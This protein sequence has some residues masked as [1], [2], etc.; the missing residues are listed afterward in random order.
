MGQILT[1]ISG[2]GRNGTV[3]SGII[4]TKDGLLFSNPNS[5]GVAITT[6]ET[7]IG[8]ITISLRF[9]VNATTGVQ[10]IFTNG[11]FAMYAYL[12]AI[13][14][15]RNGA[16]PETNNNINFNTWYN[17][18]IASTSA[19]VTN[20]YLNG[21][22]LTTITLTVVAGSNFYIGYDPLYSNRGFIG[23]IAD[24]RIYNRVLTLQEIKDYNNSFIQ[25]TLLEDYSDAGAD[26]QVSV[27]REWT[28]TSGTF[29]VAEN[30]IRQGAAYQSNF[31]TTDSWT[32]ALGGSVVGGVTIG[33]LANCLEYT[34][35]GGS[36]FHVAQISPI[37]TIVLGGRYT[38]KGK[39]YFPASGNANGF[40]IASSDGI[41]VYGTFTPITKDAWYEFSLNYT[42]IGGNFN[43]FRVIPLVNGSAPFS[44]DGQKYYL[45]D[46]NITEIQPLQT[47]TNGTKYLE[48]ASDGVIT[49]SSNT[50]YGSW[51]F[52]WY[53]GADGNGIRLN[54]IQ[55]SASLYTTGAGYML[56]IYPD[57]SITLYRFL[58]GAATPLLNTSA[59]YITNNTWYRMRI[60][61]TTTG[62]F[63]LLIK[64]GT[65]APTA[66]YDGWTLLGV[67]G[68]SNPVTD[69]TYTTSNYLVMILKG[70]DRVTNIKITNGLSSL[71]IPSTWLYGDNVLSQFWGDNL[72]LE[73]W[74]DNL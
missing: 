68:G 1:D 21:V 15:S 54:F 39:I 49:T 70:L 37:S 35:S 20:L 48:C 59:S 8:D 5:N 73:L 29:K 4:Q 60:T 31:A 14:I 45:R 3:S 34:I 18:S 10:M 33:G 43:A 65:F 11:K 26:N 38:A 32:A 66:G 23:E 7:L 17:L 44:S 64:G 51:E 67:T 63:T 52:D 40:Q 24:L 55:S 16:A 25:P 58:N 57:E 27:P 53:K 22:L 72:G 28:K 42:A 61:R 50:A 6:T 74:G 56:D 36:N 71:S 30:V 41:I 19:G 13:R 46:I 47:I 69:N 62:L 9:K 12:G 2:N